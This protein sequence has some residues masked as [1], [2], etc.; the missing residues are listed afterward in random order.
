M[1]NLKAVVAGILSLAVV[2]ARAS[3]ACYVI[4]AESFAD[5]GGWV[6]DTQYMDQMGSPYLLAHGLGRPVADATTTFKATGGDY[7][8]FVRTKNWSLPWT[9]TV[10]AAD[11]PGDFRVVVNGTALP[12]APGLTGTTDAWQWVPAGMATL[13]D[14]ENTLALRDLDGF[15]GR[16]DAIAFA[17]DVRSGVALDRARD[18]ALARAHPSVETRHYDFVVTGGGIAGICTAIS[19]ARLG[20]KTALI[21]DRPILGGNNSSEVRVHVSSWSNL[22][23]YPRL[24]DVLAEI[25]PSRTGNAHPKGNYEDERKL[26][27]VLAEKNITLFLNE[28]V[29]GVE[30]NAAGAIVSVTSQNTLTGAKRRYV[31]PLFADCTGDGAVGYL[32]GADYAMGREAK[33][34]YNEPW[35]PE[36]ADMLTL[37]SSVQWY[38]GNAGGRTAFPLKP[39]MYRFTDANGSPSLRGDWWWEAGLGR[40]QIKEGEYIR[41]YGLYVAYSNWAYTKNTATNK[42]DFADKELKW[43]AYVAGRRESRRLMGDFV[44]TEND[45]MERRL[46]PDGTCV[47][48][49]TIDLH[50]PQTKEETNFDGE[51]F[52]ADSFN[53]VIWPYPIPYRCFYSRNV[54]NLF[55]AGRDISVSH[56][57]LGT[58]RVQ[59]THGMMGEVVGMAAAVCRRRGCLP[60]AVYTDYFADLK[61]LME[62]G[63]GDGKVHPPQMYNFQSSLDPELMKRDRMN[64]QYGDARVLSL[65]VYRDKAAGGWL[66]QIVGVVWGW[67]TEFRWLDPLKPMPLEMVPK[68]IKWTREDCILGLDNDD[69]SLDVQ[70]LHLLAEKGVDVTAREAGIAF[71]NQI[72]RLWAA[73]ARGRLNL[74]CG[75]AP[76][77]SSHPSFNNCGNDIDY[78]IESDYAGLVAPG[79]PSVPVELGE[80]FGRLM[81]YG[82]GVYAGMMIGAMYAEAFFET[83]VVRVVEKALAAVPAA[84]DVA[85]LTRQL[86]AW[87]RADPKNWEAIQPKIRAMT[88]KD[89][90]GRID[91]RQNLA[92]VLMGLLYGNGNLEDTIVISMRGGLDSDC[93]PSSA[94]GILGTMLGAKAFDPKYTAN[95][96]KDHKIV[97][98]P[99]SFH[100]L[101]AA[102]EKVASAYVLRAGGAIGEIDGRGTCFVIPDRKAVAPKYEPT[103]LAEKKTTPARFTEEE[104]RRIR[105][106]RIYFAPDQPWTAWYAVRQGDL[107]I[108]RP[109][110]SRWVLDPTSA[111]CNRHGGG[112]GVIGACSTNRAT[113]VRMLWHREMTKDAKFPLIAAEKG[114]DARVVIRIDGKT[115]G[116]TVVTDATP[117]PL[118][119]DETPYL[120]KPVTLEFL[121][122]PHTH[123]HGAARFK[124]IN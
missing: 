91:C 24:G 54:P 64:C 88:F 99:Y 12:V 109:G 104:F 82:E 49:W 77:D 31:A 70:F 118:G 27:A 66:G 46:Q 84:S 5:R 95:M 67:D 71:A 116:E 2:A 10:P 35:A 44:L 112:Y 98:S 19:A 43:V 41:D 68:N 22:P 50:F 56:I 14:G 38:A 110:L 120:G 60:R 79:M 122:F 40:D 90:N 52:Y 7:R 65:A 28:R 55:M 105:H 16:C 15:D 57:A 100:E 32:A 92:F 94:A 42:A 76:P 87:H 1:N 59:R 124:D 61:A 23:P 107:E 97:D 93:N 74:R 17:A 108:V 3:D 20:L 11:R 121:V 75:I 111:F 115:V 73:N 48:T 89:S 47:T 58:T 4:E 86:L 37:G 21:Q 106:P 119:I 8:V 6:V 114:L 83:N 53:H 62:K 29:N 96:P 34:V 63:V 72:T 33:S 30:T 25:A 117:R 101:V 123:D 80:K 85:K 51:P 45:L 26:N 103:W 102:S 13:K 36:K 9:K 78:Q 18:E 39:W 113:G 81:N 69:V